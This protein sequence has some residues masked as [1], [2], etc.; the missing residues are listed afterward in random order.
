MPALVWW[1]TTGLC[2]AFLRCLCYAAVF[3]DCLEKR[4]LINYQ[5]DLHQI[6]KLGRHVA[7]DVQ[8]GIRFAIGQ[9]TLPRQPILVAKSAEIGDTFPSWDLHSRM[10]G[11]MAKQ[12]DALTPLM[13]SLHRVKIG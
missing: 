2:H 12:M 4:D 13:S 5:T 10:D 1:A 3:N 7:V 9:G 11:S 6:F 8:F